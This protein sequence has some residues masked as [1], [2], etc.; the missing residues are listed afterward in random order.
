MSS[1]RGTLVIV[2]LPKF[3]VNSLDLYSGV[4]TLII[5]YYIF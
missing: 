1:L 4:M 2:T 5:K 3:S